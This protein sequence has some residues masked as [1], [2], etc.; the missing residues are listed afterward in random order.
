MLFYEEK[1]KQEVLWRKIIVAYQILSS[2]YLL[3][4]SICIPTTEIPLW[5]GHAAIWLFLT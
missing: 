2:M 1:Q 5:K 4:G 3:R